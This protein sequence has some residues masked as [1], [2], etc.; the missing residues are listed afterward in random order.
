MPRVPS[1]YIARLVRRSAEEPVPAYGHGGGIV[2][3][4]RSRV[5]ARGAALALECVLLGAH[6]VADMGCAR[7]TARRRT[8]LVVIEKAQ[9]SGG[10]YGD[11]DIAD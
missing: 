7:V 11:Q 4:R 1:S 2:F 3:G 9:G 6:G 5:A 8:R 10:E